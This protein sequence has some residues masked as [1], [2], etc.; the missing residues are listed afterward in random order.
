MASICIYIQSSSSFIITRPQ[1]PLCRVFDDGESNEALSRG[2]YSQVCVSAHRSDH[3]VKRPR[4]LYPNQHARFAELRS[5]LVERCAFS[6]GVAR[7]RQ[8]AP[9]E[10]VDRC[11]GTFHRRFSLL[12]FLHVTF[13]EKH[14][15][16]SVT[17]ASLAQI[18]ICT[19][20]RLTRRRS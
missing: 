2:V 4:C 5:A 9:T 14:V 11:S 16:E 10:H 12:F 1:R 20:H 19:Q 17:K 8:T 6:D 18:T 13:R 7:R 15:D 3:S